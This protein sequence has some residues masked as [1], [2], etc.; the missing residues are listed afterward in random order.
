MEENRINTDLASSA[1]A[2]PAELEKTAHPEME[3][4][5]TPSR[6]SRGSYAASRFN[7]VRHVPLRKV[8]NFP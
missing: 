6:E 7:A 1:E 4:T 3:I 2:E 8:S 5:S